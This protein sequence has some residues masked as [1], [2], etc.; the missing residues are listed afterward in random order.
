MGVGGQHQDSAALP[1]RKRLATHCTE[2]WLDPQSQSGRVRKSFSL[3]GFDR[4][5]LQ[6]VAVLCIDCAIPAHNVVYIGV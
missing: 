1:L 2:G 6:A 4:R 3:P 5:T